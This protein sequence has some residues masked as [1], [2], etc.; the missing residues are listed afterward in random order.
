MRSA[1]A[2]IWAN[3]TTASSVSCGRGYLTPHFY[4]FSA[5]A[6]G[7]TEDFYLP[8]SIAVDRQLAS[9]EYGCGTTGVPAAWEQLL[10]SD[11]PWLQYWLEIPR[12]G[13]VRDFRAFLENYAAEQQRLGRFKWRPLTSLQDVTQWLA[14]Q[15][16]VPDEVRINT[17]IAMGFLIVCLINAIGLM[18]AKFASRAVELSVRRALG[19]S[20]ADLFLQCVAEAMLIGLLGGLLGLGLTEVGLSALRSLRGVPSSDSAYG[21]LLSLNLEM[22]LITFSVAIIATICCGLY[23]A[24]RASRVQP[25]WQLKAQ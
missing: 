1:K 3:G 5:A 22:V 8:L 23:P 10:G 18:L 19:A 7:E 14:Y 11:C 20:R 25:G 4:D 2:S 13:Q 15:R 6:F 24:F 16:V 9:D 17:M 12:A 21:R